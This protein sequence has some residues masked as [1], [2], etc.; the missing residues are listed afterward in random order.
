MQP[1]QAIVPVQLVRPALMERVSRVVIAVIIRVMQMRIVTLVLE[2]VERVFVV[3][4]F[5][6]ART[7]VLLAL[8]TVVNAFV[9]MGYAAAPRTVRLVLTI[10]AHVRTVPMAKA[11][12]ALM[13]VPPAP[14]TVIA[15]LKNLHPEP[16]PKGPMVVEHALQTPTVHRG[17]DSPIASVVER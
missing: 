15:L 16:V 11:A 12:C 8:L 2:I 13:A 17:R 4:G 10:V 3:M 5:V 1:V 9:V 14:L 7:T 6:M